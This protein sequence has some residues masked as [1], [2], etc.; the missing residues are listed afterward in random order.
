M[1]HLAA[2]KRR[3][4]KLITIMTLLILLL[5]NVSRAEE[6]VWEY[7]MQPGDNIWKIAHELLTDWRSWQEVERLN[8]VNN[9]RLMAAG[10]ILR[11]P[12]SMIQRRQARIQLIEVSGPVTLISAADKSEKSLTD[13]TL[14]E[15]DLIKTG[16]N[17][18]AL[19]KF[20]DNT[21][22]LLNA[23]SEFVINQ[24]SI[25]GSNRNVIDINVLLKAGEAEIRA[26]PAQSPGSR[27]VIETPSAFATTRG[28]VYRI[29]ADKTQTA[30]EVT[31]GRIDVANTLGS[32]KVRQKFGTLT[33][34]NSAPQKPK[35]LLVAP[36]VPTIKTIHYLP[37]RLSWNE[38][39][40]AVSYRSQLSDQEE[41]SRII[42]DNLGKPAKLNIPASLKDGQY[43]LRVKAADA[44]G[45]QGLESLQSFTID[46]RPFPPSIQSPRPKDPVYTGK[47][48]F[49]WTQ[50]EE[51][52]EY[53]FELSSE[54][55]FTSLT[56]PASILN[57]QQLTT[58]IAKAGVY[59][60]RV[61]SINAEGKVGPRGHIN[62][63]TVRPT[64]ATPDLREP[65]TSKTELG[66]SW[67]ED[68]TATHYQ[69]QLANNKDFSKIIA[70]KEVS[71]AEATLKK[72]ASG[73]YFMRVRGFDSDNY[74]GSWSS[75]QKIEVPVD[76]YMPAI[77]WST[78]ALIILL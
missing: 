50:P 46:A 48:T 41:F 12:T 18:S 57:D 55:D 11:I 45:L 38:I 54:D 37:A 3:I 59:F 67:K 10:T 20:E 32:T 16:S 1:P 58:S 4:P 40:G 22:I 43:W 62:Q 44:N 23:E 28:T 29:R 56:H 65:T 8:N 47:T 49:V 39:T 72:P 26:N 77:I 27:F 75:T 24:A 2:N 61:T 13:Q 60:W 35:R 33:T 52:K 6:S 7:E 5:S 68:E 70:D 19:L 9:D 78:L 76:S 73:T 42:L 51:A 66:F 31:Q 25:I 69:I 14:Q 63:I 30:A 21:Q 36:A 53:R 34:K 71:T 17:A 64:P 15:G 74:A